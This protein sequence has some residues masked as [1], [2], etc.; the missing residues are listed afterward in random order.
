LKNDPRQQPYD[1]ALKGLFEK[2]A[3]LI[4]PYLLPMVRLEATPLIEDEDDEAEE[5]TEKENKAEKKEGAELNIEINR[6]TLKADLLYRAF[7]NLD[8]IIL[9][10][11]LQTKH[12]PDLQRRLM[13]YHGS[14]HLK[15]NKP[16]FILVIYVFEEGPEDLT[17][18]DT[19]DDG[20]IL[21]SIYPKVIRLR[22]LDSEQIVREHQI[23]LYA[24]LP[25]TKKPEVQLLKQA[26]Q[27]M[28]EYH[29]KQDLSEHLI[30]FQS[31]LGRTKTISKK[32]KQIIEE[33]LKV[34][35]QIDPLIR[36]NPTVVSIAA[37]AEARG[38]ARGKIEGLQEAILE[39][40]SES[41]PALV[42]SQI[43]RTITFSQNI[44]Q[45]KKFHRQIAR[46]SDEQEALALLAQCFPSDVEARSHS[47]EVRSHS[48]YKYMQDM[49]LDVVSDHFLSQVVTQVQQTIAPIQDTQ[50]LR[51]F[52][53][54]LFRASNEQE[55]FA[56]LAEC[57]P[58]H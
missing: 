4:I 25:S 9:I 6:S 2:H 28:H 31:I 49:I 53:R 18:H 58:T 32:E 16:V 36:E 30:W 47:E 13:A 23:P 26:L 38:E 34:Q 40:A 11:E 56:L 41:L 24:L 37:E 10:V 21:A 17:Y 3:T 33:V 39:L 44:E 20:N 48:E 1:G 51:K 22:D 55:V 14:L 15:Y 8:R 12:D 43:Q 45:L 54:Q 46:V 29:N 7:Y 50:L 57:F 52:N 19:C 42:V 5:K 35:Y 27:E